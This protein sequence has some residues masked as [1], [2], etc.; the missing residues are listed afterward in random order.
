[1]IG[2][3]IGLGY[4]LASE[5]IANSGQVYDLNPALVTWLPSL[6]LLAITVFAIDRIR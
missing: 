1:M 4:Y 3:L 6:V 2:V 5:M